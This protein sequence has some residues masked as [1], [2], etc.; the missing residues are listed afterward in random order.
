MQVDRGKLGTPQID[1]RG[2]NGA[3]IFA[4]RSYGVGPEAQKLHV[5]MLSKRGALIGTRRGR[6]LRNFA[7][8]LTSEVVSSTLKLR[9][10]DA[11]HSCVAAVRPES[12]QKIVKKS[13]LYRFGSHGEF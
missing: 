11:K 12:G 7:V 13:L 6:D 8:F 10:N 3:I 9:Q 5:L 2:S 4:I 1:P